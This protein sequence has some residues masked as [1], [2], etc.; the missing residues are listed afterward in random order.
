M[1]Q[2]TLHLW[3]H[4]CVNIPAKKMVKGKYQGTRGAQRRTKSVSLKGHRW[5]VSEKGLQRGQYIS[6]VLNDKLVV[7]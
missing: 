1:I 5:D 3:G 2:G 4:R 6:L 7:L